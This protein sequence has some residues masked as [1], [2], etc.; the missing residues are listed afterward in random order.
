MLLGVAK[1]PRQRFDDLASYLVM[2][3]DK[4]MFVACQFPPVG[5]GLQG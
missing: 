2:N 4:V 3:A 5:D 1:E